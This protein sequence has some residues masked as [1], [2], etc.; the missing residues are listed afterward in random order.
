MRNFLLDAEPKF[1]QSSVTLEGVKFRLTKV[2]N[3]GCYFSVEEP[4]KEKDQITLTVQ[5]MKALYLLLSVND[6]PPKVQ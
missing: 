3:N 6:K 5:E 2:R 4:G 1:N